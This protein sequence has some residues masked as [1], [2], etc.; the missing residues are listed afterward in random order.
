MNYSVHHDTQFVSDALFDWEP[1]QLLEST[2]YTVE[3]A[4]IRHISSG[5]VDQPL[6]QY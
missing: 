6:I 1:V 3:R 4:E 2:C 5:S